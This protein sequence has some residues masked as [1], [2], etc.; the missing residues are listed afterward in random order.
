MR[1][2]PWSP[3]M[4]RADRGATMTSTGRLR[5]SRGVPSQQPARVSL[6]TC[7][8]CRGRDERSNLLRVVAVRSGSSVVL[9]PDL[10]R[11]RPGRGAWVHDDPAC[12][13]QAERRKALTRALRVTGQVDASPVRDHVHRAPKDQH[14][15]DGAHRARRPTTEGGYDADE[16]PMRTRQ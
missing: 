8:G 7:L 2:R 16:H 4:P 6:R 5:P 13:D 15:T 14:D 9:E 10:R 12:L 1:V 11:R 3:E